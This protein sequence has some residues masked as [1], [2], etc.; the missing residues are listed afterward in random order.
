MSNKKLT[1]LIGYPGSGKS[2]AMKSL[3]YGPFAR[4]S[5]PFKHIIYKSGA[6]Q[7]G[8]IREEYSGTDALPMNVQP[9]VI[10]W[11]RE[12]EYKNIY[13][14]GDRLGND[15]FFR[16]VLEAGFELDI[17]L[18]D[19]TEL[20]SRYRVVQRSGREFND[21]WFRG[22]LTKVD[23]LRKNWRKYIKVVDS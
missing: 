11:L 18:I 10:E 19:I 8:D 22:R 20:G 9:V 4:E 14:E 5:K 1:Y 16:A 6:V 3:L 12:T 15:K 17:I 7:I 13:A 2:T 21:A 23:N